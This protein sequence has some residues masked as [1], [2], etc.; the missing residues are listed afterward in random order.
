[1]QIGDWKGELRKACLPDSYLAAIKPESQRATQADAAKEPLLLLNKYKD[2]SPDFA[3]LSIDSFTYSLE[4]E[5]ICFT[6]KIKRNNT[7]NA[8][9]ITKRLYTPFP[10]PCIKLVI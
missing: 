3:I 9:K 8:K 4:I 10:R 5:F 7:R 1:F 6:P 2:S